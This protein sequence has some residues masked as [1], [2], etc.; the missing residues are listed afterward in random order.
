[1]TGQFNIIGK[2]LDFSTTPF[3]PPG[4]KII[5]HNSVVHAP[6]FRLDFF[7]S[8]KQVSAKIGTGK[9]I[10]NELDLT[11]TLGAHTLDFLLE[12]QEHIPIEWERTEINNVVRCIFFCGTVYLN[13]KREKCVRCLC[14]FDNI[15]DW[16]YRNLDDIF[17]NNFSIALLSSNQPS[18]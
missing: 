14:K 5:R 13:D 2:N 12:N 11:K 3:I 6:C 10:M 1:M 9:E 17:G 18:V 4:W 16:S 15:W 7:I 8:I